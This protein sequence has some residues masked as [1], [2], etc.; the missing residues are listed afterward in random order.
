MAD[1]ILCRVENGI[2]VVTMNRPESANSLSISLMIGLRETLNRLETDDSTKVIILTGSG[3]KTFCAGIDVK[4]RE[5]MTQEEVFRSRPLHVMPLFRDIEEMTKPLIAAVN[6]VALGGGAELALACDIRIASENASFGLI[7]IRWGIIPPG[8]S[9][10][11]LPRIVGSGKAKELIFTGR[12]I[13]AKEAERI[14][15]YN[16]VVPSGKLFDTTHKLAEEIN[17]N[18]LVAVRQAKRTMNLGANL[19]MAMAFDYE[20][21]K[22]CYFVGDKEGPGLKGKK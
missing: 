7:E 8:G 6:G 16:Q 9:C 19:H 10:Q 4:E 14:G 5:K 18:S 21:S 17:K 20:A 12:I 11:R 13:D 1:E 15:I 22:E 2:A 3:E